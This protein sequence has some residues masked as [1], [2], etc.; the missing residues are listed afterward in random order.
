MPTCS[1]NNPDGSHK[2]SCPQTAEVEID[3]F[4]AASGAADPDGT[5]DV[6]WDDVNNDDSLASLTGHTCH[7]VAHEWAQHQNN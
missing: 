4:P 7:D 1:C 2:W 6:G 3:L 5:P